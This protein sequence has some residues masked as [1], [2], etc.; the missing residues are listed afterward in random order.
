MRLPNGS[1]VNRE[2][3]APFYERLAGKFRWPTHLAMGE[4]N[5]RIYK[6]YGTENFS[7]LRKLALFY[8]EKDT[9]TKGGIRFKQFL[10]AQDP[11]YLPKL[12]KMQ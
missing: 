10:A 9:L 8:L 2:V 1:G 7:S 6:E 11:L 3:H 5:C 12:L 4:D